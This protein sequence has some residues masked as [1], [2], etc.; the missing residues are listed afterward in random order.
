MSPKL[1]GKVAVVTGASKGI[2]ASRKVA[3]TAGGINQDRPERSC[4]WSDLTVLL[5]ALRN[6]VREGFSGWTP[7]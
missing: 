3:L 7:G 1:L 6:G 2:G 5:S 4:L